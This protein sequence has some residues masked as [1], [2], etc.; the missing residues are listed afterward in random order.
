VISRAL[1]LGAAIAI[2]APVAAQERTAA[3][4]D[5]RKSQVL[6]FEDGLRRAVEVGGEDVSKRVLEFVPVRLALDGAPIVRGF[7]LIGYG[8][9]FDVQVPDL[10]SAGL[11]LALMFQRQPAAPA[12][13]SA[14]AGNRGGVVPAANGGPVSDDPMA[15]PQAAPSI[16]F[17]P[18]AAYRSS[19]RA[20]LIDAIIDNS[21]VLTLGDNDTLT[22]TANGVD[23]STSYRVN[24]SRLI[25]EIKASDLL[26]LRQ[27]KISRDEAKA[28]IKVTQF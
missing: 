28:R 8:Y 27:G 26:A 11:A 21:G 19:V 2:A 24:S 12:G 25:L 13:S 10:S 3:G 9:H 14:R 22:V 16:G 18:A 6:M 4:V 20:A 7:P 23:Q 5:A 15:S 1:I 17:D